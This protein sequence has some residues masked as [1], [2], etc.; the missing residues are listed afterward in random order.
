MPLCSLGCFPMCSITWML[1]LHPW[2]GRARVLHQLHVIRAWTELLKVLLF[3]ENP[4][5][6]ED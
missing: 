5:K 6:R 2:M 3:K 1:L 4:K